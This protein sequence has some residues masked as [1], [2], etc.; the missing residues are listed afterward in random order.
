MRSARSVSRASTI[1]RAAHGSGRRARGAARSS[2]ALRPDLRYDDVR[3]NVDTRLRKLDEGV[4]RR[5]AGNGRNAAPRRAA[6]YTIPFEPK[7]V[8]PAV[9]QGALAIEM[10]ANDP[11]AE[12]LHDILADEATELAVTAERAFLRA[13]R[14]GCRAPVGAH[15]SYEDGV[16][17]LSVVAASP[18]G[19]LMLRGERLGVVRDRAAA[20]DIGEAVAD[21]L[22]SQGAALITIDRP[23][24]GRLFLLPRTQ[25]RPSRI[26]AALREAG[27]EVVEAVDSATA[28]RGLAGRIPDAI[29]FPS[30]GAVR[31][32]AA[33]LAN[34]LSPHPMSQRWVRLVGS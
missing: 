29:L 31:A 16:L 23:L 30:S 15:G 21:F 10:R 9:G 5:R 11:N 17:R 12:R 24:A 7:D 1:S 3:G 22:L 20:E 34:L 28:L 25:E 2:R 27:A 6:K 8:T 18:D 32:I 4:R 13:M 19:S 14:G 33:Y 26:A